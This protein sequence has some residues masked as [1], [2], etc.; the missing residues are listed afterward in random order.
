MAYLPALQKKKAQQ[1]VTSAFRGINRNAEASDGEFAKTLNLS[2]REYPLLCT[3][4]QRGTIG[5]LMAPE[6]V[7]ARQEALVWL[8]GENV[9][10]NGSQVS[11]ITLSTDA[12]ML[13]KRIVSFGAYVL[14]FPDKVYFNTIDP[15]DK[16]FIE[17][18]FELGAS[19]TAT[20]TMCR[21][22][23]SDYENVTTGD[24]PPSSPDHGDYWI[25]TSEETHKLMCYSATYGS[26]NQ[27]LTVY[28]R[29][30]ATGIGAIFPAGDAIEISGA[31]APSGASQTAQDQ[32]A[33]LNG[34]HYVYTATDDS[35]VIIGLLDQ[36]VTQT[37]GLKASRSVPD[38]E[39]IIESENR[40]WGCHYGTD[41]N[42]QTLNEIYASKLGDFK[43]W[44]VYQGLSTDSYTVSIGSDGPW[45]GAIA[46][47]GYPC[48]FKEKYLHK[49]YGSQPKNFQTMTTQLR[50]VKAGCGK[51]LAIVDG[52]LIYV[53]RT[54][55]EAYDGS[56]P[57]CISH[58]FGEAAFEDCT[59]GTFGGR[60]YLSAKEDDT[61]HI[62]TYDTRTA[63]WLEEDG[64]EA[65]DFTDGINDLY[66]LNADTGEIYA[67]LGTEGDMEETV[68]W[69][70]ETGLMT[71]ETVDHKFV[72][73]YNIRAQIEGGSQVKAQ[74]RYNSKG[75]W[76]DKM[77]LTN[78]ARTARTLLMPVY[79]HRCDHLH[80]RLCGRGEIKI[81]SIARILT[82][83]GD[84]QGAR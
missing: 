18:N 76:Y 17:G 71:W 4:K 55:V 20:Y 19:A 29:V 33:A 64:F 57:Q 10:Y 70:A 56:L 73:R 39:Y 6:G 67:M 22:D 9:F 46:Y 50:G 45:T 47:G 8:D 77:D 37:G 7:A 38:M 32:V 60:Y 65:V 43:N 54:G 44:R 79:P 34:S 83:G 14:I 31:E 13:P 16:G 2:T 68:F 62:Y 36:S 35:I 49:M 15:D 25:D 41:E 51:S 66:A 52:T 84:G 1:V 28:T 48:F 72:T 74:I 82:S 63:I 81:Y 40:L 12:A 24:T 53:S 78:K 69:S 59:A 5:T 23:G 21:V 30:E 80:M 75:P 26:W 27:I 42:G 61:W 58:N 11:G 3:R